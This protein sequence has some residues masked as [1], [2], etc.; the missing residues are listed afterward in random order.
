[1]ALEVQAERATFTE[2]L[3]LA[4]EVGREALAA[5]EDVKLRILLAQSLARERKLD[6]AA[7]ELEGRQGADPAKWRWGAFH[8]VKFDHPLGGAIPFGLLNIGP[9]ERPGDD[10]TVNDAPYRF[11]T[12]YDLRSHASLRTVVDLA[13]LDNSWSVLPTGQ[14]GQPYAKHWGD[15]TPLWLRGDL[16]PMPLS[17]GRID[18][19]GT[20]VL[21]AR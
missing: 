11:T 17:R 2:R 9:F 21:R 20:L 15:Q 12:P 18:A 4:L 8:R 5:S 16:K 13:D 10:D 1:M 14:S 19:E 6:D 3:D 7:K